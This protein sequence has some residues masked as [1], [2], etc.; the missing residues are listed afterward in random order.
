MPRLRSRAATIAARIRY[1]LDD[2]IEMPP[3][4]TSTAVPVNMLIPA[5]M[6][7]KPVQLG[8]TIARP[9]VLAV[10]TSCCWSTMPSSPASA[11]PLATTTTPAAPIAPASSTTPIVR[12]AP[13]SESTASTGAPTCFSDGD[14]GRPYASLAFGLTRC[15]ST[16]PAATAPSRLAMA[17]FDI[18][19]RSLAPT[20]A[21]ERAL[22]RRVRLAIRSTNGLLYV[23][24]DSQG[25][26]YWAARACFRPATPSA[27]MISLKVR[28]SGAVANLL[29]VRVSMSAVSAAGARPPRQRHPPRRR[30]RAG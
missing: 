18:D 26:S 2:T 5:V 28:P 30:R 13:T 6:L 9:W 8:P 29:A 27:A 21:I 7:A 11:N 20:I 3:A 22:S 15:R 25:D 4:R 14:V 19:R 10:A 1:P 16:P 12:S 24:R 23:G 17:T